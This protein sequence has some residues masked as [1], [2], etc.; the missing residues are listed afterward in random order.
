MKDIFCCP[1]QNKN[2]RRRREI[3]PQRFGFFFAQI[4]LSF[5]L[6]LSPFQSSFHITSFSAILKLDSLSTPCFIVDS[7]LHTFNPSLIFTFHNPIFVFSSAFPLIY[8]P[9]IRPH[10]CLLGTF[11]S[12]LSLS[13][14]F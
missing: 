13:L 3:L 10:A 2:E 7:H 9:S 12:N 5:L 11:S 4:F 6:W 1:S 14:S 8:L